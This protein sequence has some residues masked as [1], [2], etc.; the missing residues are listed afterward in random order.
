VEGSRVGVQLGDVGVRKELPLSA[1]K[2]ASNVGYEIDGG[3]LLLGLSFGCDGGIKT[4]LMGSMKVPSIA[5]VAGSSNKIA[6]FLCWE[7][8]YFLA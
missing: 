3:D 7:E 8:L 4:V 1:A 2:Y 5:Y 6:K